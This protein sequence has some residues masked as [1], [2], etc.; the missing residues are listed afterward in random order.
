MNDDADRREACILDE[1]TSWPGVTAGPGDLGGE[2]E[3]TVGRRS[4]GH[5]HG[6]HQ[7][8]IPFPRRVRDELVAAGRTGPHH[9]Y[10]DSGWTTLRI[11]D[12]ADATTAVELL[13]INYDRVTLRHPA[14]RD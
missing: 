9:V 12:D 10:P 7:A 2:T 4:L 3:F 6:G 5:I 13:R 1:V 11:R 14:G 8:D